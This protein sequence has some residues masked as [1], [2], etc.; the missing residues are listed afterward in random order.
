LSLG[1]SLGWNIHN[2][3]LSN[4]SREPEQ[5]P[6]ALSLVLRYCSPLLPHCSLLLLTAPPCSLT[7][8]FA[9]SLLPLL[10]LVAPSRACLKRPCSRSQPKTEADDARIGV[11]IIYIYI[12]LDLD[13]TRDLLLTYSSSL[14]FCASDCFVHHVRPLQMC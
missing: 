6:C 2:I 9:P 11:Y 7:A 14:C 4:Y 13:A 1:S 8:P 12:C 3:R 5:A 10:S